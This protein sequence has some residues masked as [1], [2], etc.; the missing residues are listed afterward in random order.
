MT[1]KK[2][3]WAMH[4]Q[5]YPVGFEEDR[6]FMWQHWRQSFGQSIQD[7]RTE[8]QNQTMMLELD[9]DDHELFMKFIRDALIT[10]TAIE[11]KNKHVDKKDDK[12][13]SKQFGIGS[14]SKSAEQNFW[15]KKLREKD[16]EKRG[17]EKEAKRALI[18]NQTKE[19]QEMVQPDS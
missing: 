1:C 9:L 18:V 11:V 10:A 17:K 3:K 13:N 19:I 6:W 12:N 14:S 7:Y 15:R 5:L 16:N 8:F 4:T 2:F